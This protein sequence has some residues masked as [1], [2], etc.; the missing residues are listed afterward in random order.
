MP[1]EALESGA[2]VAG[3]CELPDVG[4]GTKHRVLLTTG[5]AVNRAGEARTSLFGLEELCSV[6]GR[7]GGLGLNCQ[8]QGYLGNVGLSGSL[9]PRILISW[10]HKDHTV[11]LLI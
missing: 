9:S 7:K 4:L 11:L 10:S 6:R 3:G 8:I 2:G 5:P 1:L